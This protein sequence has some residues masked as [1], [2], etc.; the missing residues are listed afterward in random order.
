MPSICIPAISTAQ[1]QVLHLVD[2]VPMFLCAGAFVCPHQHATTKCK[3]HKI[4]HVR[5]LLIVLQVF[6]P[7]LSCPEAQAAALAAELLQDCSDEVQHQE[8]RSS[9]PLA[10]LHI[11]LLSVVSLLS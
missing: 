6:S 5:M 3:E 4:C 1:D 7:H 10:Q 11:Q 9:S 8:E 2:M